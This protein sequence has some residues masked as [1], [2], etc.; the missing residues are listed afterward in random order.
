MQDT[1]PTTGGDKETNKL[2]M[3][4]APD[5]L[6]GLKELKELFLTHNFFRGWNYRRYHITK[7]IILASK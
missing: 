5:L 3:P 6:Q 1:E 4:T 7:S 2:D